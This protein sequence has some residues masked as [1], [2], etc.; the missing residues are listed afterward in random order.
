MANMDTTHASTEAPQLSF[1][2]LELDLSPAFIDNNI[3]PEEAWAK[4]PCFYT[5]EIPW[6]QEPHFFRDAL[7]NDELDDSEGTL[8]AD[9]ASFLTGDDAL[10]TIPQIKTEDTRPTL[11]LD[12]RPR[13]QQWPS[14]HLTPT[15]PLARTPSKRQRT[16][17]QPDAQEEHETGEDFH[18]L[19]R[20]RSR[21]EVGGFRCPSCDIKPFDRRCDLNK[22]EK[23]KHTLRTFRPHACQECAARFCWPKDVKR[24]LKQVHPSL[25][26]VGERRTSMA[27]LTR[28]LVGFKN[29]RIKATSPKSP[30]AGA[31]EKSIQVTVDK[32]TFVKVDVSRLAD[33]SD[34]RSRITE[35]LGYSLEMGS[36]INISRY[37][38]AFPFEPLSEEAL[39]EVVEQD[40]D[41]DMNL[42]LQVSVP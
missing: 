11:T 28:A 26:P 34:L 29:L 6:L 2:E 17:F 38:R 27:W 23:H 19:T 24:H 3:D 4:A 37:H 32:Q 21:K 33:V 9:D 20:K 1:H 14:Q 15:S 5:A 31:V 42:K 22:H 25:S 13:T 18:N 10:P 8:A 7:V 30:V 40:A 12:C 16:D 39:M 41:A 35:A 36:M